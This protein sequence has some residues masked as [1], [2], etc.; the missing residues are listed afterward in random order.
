MKMGKK[1]AHYVQFSLKP[2]NYDALVVMFFLEPDLEEINCNFIFFHF[3]TINNVKHS[4][5]TK[6][7]NNHQCR[8]KHIYSKRKS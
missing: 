2:K 3:L 1:D 6:I 4:L 7:K 5:N 8:S